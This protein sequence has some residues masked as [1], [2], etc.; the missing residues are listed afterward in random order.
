[1]ALL[2]PERRELS[3]PLPL[4]FLITI[5]SVLGLV[6]LYHA[7][8]TTSG[9]DLKL[10]MTLLAAGSALGWLAARAAVGRYLRQIE[11]K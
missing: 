2:E 4:W 3:E 11:P 9:I 5:L 8:F 10:I 6:S 1:M 7:N